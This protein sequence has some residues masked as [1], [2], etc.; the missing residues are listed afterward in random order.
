MAHMFLLIKEKKKREKK[1]VK[2]KIKSSTSLTC[3]IV[4]TFP[5]EQNHCM[6]TRSRESNVISRHH[7]GGTEHAPKMA[8]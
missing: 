3:A 7:S 2:Y 1:R 5:A 8:L 4:L 6:S